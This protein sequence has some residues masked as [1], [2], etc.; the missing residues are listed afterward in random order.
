MKLEVELLKKRLTASSC[1]PDK[2]IVGKVRKKWRKYLKRYRPLKI[3]PC[4][5]MCHH[6]GEAMWHCHCPDSPQNGI[7][8]MPWN[9][10]RN[11]LP[12]NGLMMFLHRQWFDKDL[13]DTMKRR[14]VKTI[15]IKE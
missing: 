3:D 8:V 5:E 9:T 15:D 13:E 11:Y 1:E 14:P 2:A 12:N 6:V 4:C 7:N 10:C